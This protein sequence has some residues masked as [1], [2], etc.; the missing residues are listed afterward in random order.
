M[1]AGIRK[2]WVVRCESDIW[3]ITMG[4]LQDRSRGMGREKGLEEKAKVMFKAM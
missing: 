3:G 2:K 4:E 1:Q